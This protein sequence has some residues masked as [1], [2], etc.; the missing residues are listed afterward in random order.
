MPQNVR[1][2]KKAVYTVLL[3]FSVKDYVKIFYIGCLFCL[4][5][6]TFAGNNI[7]L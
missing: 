6:T 4:Q 5:L 2:C 3:A 1:W 7:K